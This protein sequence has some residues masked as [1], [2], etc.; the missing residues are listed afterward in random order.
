VTSRFETDDA[1][2]FDS[3]V[4]SLLCRI[5]PFA[6]VSR[7]HLAPPSFLTAFFLPLLDSVLAGEEMLV[8]T[9][10]RLCEIA[11]FVFFIGLAT[12]F[13][14]PANPLPLGL[15]IFFDAMMHIPFFALA[16]TTQANFSCSRPYL[17]SFAL[18]F[19]IPSVV[20]EEITWE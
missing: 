18:A 17:V 9:M 16:T 4:L 19:T 2:P 13:H 11:A 15:W 1:D 3:F 12:P 14:V 20:S 8:A 5:R 10:A 6:V 7:T